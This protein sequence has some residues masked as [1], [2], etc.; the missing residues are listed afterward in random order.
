MMLPATPGLRFVEVFLTL[1]EQAYCVKR[2][3]AAVYH[4]ATAS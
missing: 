4:A 2:V 3:D 1:E